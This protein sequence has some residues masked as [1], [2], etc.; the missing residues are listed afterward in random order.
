MNSR[1]LAIKPS[2]TVASALL[3]VLM[4][5]P[6]SLVD[7]VSLTPQL[8]WSKTYYGDTGR[9]IQTNDGGF[10]IAANN[11]SIL[12]YPAWQRAPMLIK[13]ASSGAVQWNRTFE[14]VGLAGIHCFSD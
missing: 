11:A 2:K 3:I 7:A 10:I 9:A 5:F 4:V 13:T 1:C 12:F 14:S 8:Q 6:L